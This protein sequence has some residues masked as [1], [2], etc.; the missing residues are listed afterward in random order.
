M[1]P[2]RR[3]RD[4]DELVDVNERSSGGVRYKDLA[5]IEQLVK[6]GADLSERRHVVYY[7]TPGHRLGRAMGDEAGARGSPSPSASRCPI[8]RSVNHLRDRGGHSRDFVIESDDFFQSLADRHGAE[9]DGW[10]A[11]V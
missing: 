11:S 9:Y 6:N 7:S 8:S 2:F 5:V 4:D 3:K 10:E 1:R